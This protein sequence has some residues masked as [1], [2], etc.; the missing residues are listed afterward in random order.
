MEV[1]DMDGIEPQPTSGCVARPSTERRGNEYEHHPRSAS[2]KEKHTQGGVK[3]ADEE[4]QD[5]R[6][7]D[8]H[9]ASIRM[10]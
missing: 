10:L 8:I 7:A 2:A 1:A 6:W 5:G 9:E 4:S 3:A